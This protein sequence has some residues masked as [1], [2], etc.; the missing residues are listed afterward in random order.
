LGRGHLRDWFRTLRHG[1][2][3]SNLSVGG[4]CHA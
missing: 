4:Y 3:P 2:Y 1:G